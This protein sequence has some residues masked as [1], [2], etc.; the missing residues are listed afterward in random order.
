[1]TTLSWPVVIGGETFNEADFEG[2]GWRTALPGMVNASIA[3]LASSEGAVKAAEA[4]ASAVLAQQWATKTDAPVAGGEWSAKRYALLASASETAV[5]TSAGVATTK[6]GEA[7]ASAAGAA[8]SAATATTK[9]G[10]AGASATAAAGSAATAGTKATEAAASALG[11]AGSATT[12]TNKAA[13]AGAAALAAAGSAADALASKI[14]A[15]THAA[16]AAASAALA[17]EAANSAAGGGI[18][19]TATDTTPSLLDAAVDVAGSITKAVLNTGANERLQLGHL[20]TDGHQHVPATGTTNNGRVLRAGA[21]AGSASWGWVAYSELTGVPS[22]FAPAAHTHG[23][24]DITAIDASKITSGIID[25]ARIP[26]AALERLS[27]VTNQ[28]ARYAL[29]TAT[30][31]LGDTV[32]QSSDGRVYALINEAQIG[33]AAGWEEYSVGLAASAPWSGITGKPTTLSGYGITDAAPSSHVGSG[34]T[35]H[36]AATTS[37]A[38][39]MAAADKTKLDAVP[40]P[41]TIATTTTVE[42]RVNASP[43]TDQVLW[44]RAFI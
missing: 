29:T 2:Y 10:E 36:A 1:M 25:I 17:L 40:T 14:D 16:A 35:A 30:V 28:A 43:T 11:A 32:K 20:T 31:Q 12:A 26:A 9:A 15:G 3:Y 21:T 7:A 5:A 27:V 8:G 23:N 34:G 24:A 22:T 13:D 41:A 18:K 38:G 19:V 44:A 37:A 33:N 42:T 6:A 4:A 39:F